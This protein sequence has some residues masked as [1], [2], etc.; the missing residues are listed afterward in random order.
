MTCTGYD[1]HGSTRSID[2]ARALTSAGARGWV[3]D[4]FDGE[5]LAGVVAEVRP[6]V[7]VHQ[8]TDLPRNLDPARIDEAVA[9]N[10]RI[11]R[12]GTFNLVVAA[13]AAGCRR[14]VAQSIAWAYAPG[15]TPH[16]ESHPLDLAARGNRAITVGGV[17][18]LESAVLS[19]PGLRGAVLRYGNLYGPG[20]GNDASCGAAPL[21]VDAAAHAALLAV[22]REVEGIFNICEPNAT[23]SA[24]RAET[25]LDWSAGFRLDAAGRKAGAV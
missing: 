6:D 18:A 21:H 16:T 9:N 17:A 2:K 23:V 19:T 5:S 7:V 24:R 4:V 12:E 25:E 13:L 22:E 8:L 1:V 3:V 14:M 20:T 11:R 10:A 15:N